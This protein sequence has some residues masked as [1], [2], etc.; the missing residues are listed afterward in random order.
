MGRPSS[1]FG[2]H[3]FVAALELGLASAAKDY[4]IAL[5]GGADSTALI[6][7]VSELG[8]AAKAIHIDHGLHP[9]SQDWASHCQRLCNQLGVP[10]EVVRITIERCGEGVEAAARRARY[11]ALA[12]AAEGEIILTAH[13]AQDQ[14]ETLLLRLVRG[15]GVDGLTGIHRLRH[16]A[17]A[18]F[19]RPLLRVEPEMI[20]DYLAVRRLSHIDDP[21]NEST[22]FDRNFLRT[23]VLP[24][25]LERWPAASRLSQHI[26]DAA[27]EQRE[28]VQATGTF[29]LGPTPAPDLDRLLALTPARRLNALRVLVVRAGY[30][31]PS[32]RRL[33][34]ILLEFEVVGEDTGQHRWTWPGGE[35]RLYRR[36]LYL[37]GPGGPQ[38]SAPGPLG[39][40]RPWQG[41]VGTLVL[42][43]EPGQ[44]IASHWL[45]DGLQVRFRKGGERIRLVGAGH[46][47]AVKDLM[48]EAGIVPWMRPLVPLIY[49]ED[50]LLAVAD[51]WLAE[52]AAA[53]KGH[54]H[55][56]RW[57][58]RPNLY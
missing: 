27:A 57:L 42:E 18:T 52:E 9:Q 8:L 49:G 17:G 10:L 12:R 51:L 14:L 26:A 45:K 7:A 33:E 23:K 32:R 34:Q 21:S 48:R 11:A 56:V 19:L 35:F 38:V 1:A 28:L 37:L 46:R 25:L 40:G 4:C 22:D 53:T 44:G 43:S 5:S 39:L 58:G 55:Q 13:H 47:R 54:G 50:R 29:D 2:K 24:P 16:H 15:T 31:P 3:P 41:G 20:A 6:A 30:T 36:K